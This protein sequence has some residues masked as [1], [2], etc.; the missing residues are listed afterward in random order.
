L[1]SI[2]QP[3]NAFLTDHKDALLTVVADRPPD[4]SSISADRWR[5]EKWAAENEIR[6]TQRMDV[7][8]MPLDDTDWSRGKCGFKMIQ[9]M[10]VATPVVVSPY[11]V[12]IDILNKGECG[13]AAM[14]ADDWYEGLE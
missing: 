12:N 6:E 10:S 9:Y 2:E 14:T 5:F 7:G 4:L 8:L 13:Y 11:G 3:I 1:R